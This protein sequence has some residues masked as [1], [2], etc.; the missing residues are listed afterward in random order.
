MLTAV[1]SLL[2]SVIGA[3]INSKAIMISATGAGLGQVAG[4]FVITWLEAMTL[5]ALAACISVV[6]RSTMG[7]VVACIVI[8]FV[9]SILSGAL[10]AMNPEPT[11][12]TLAIPTYS[13]DLLRH[14]VTSPSH[15]GVDGGPVGAAFL[16]LLGWTALLAAGAVFLFQRQDLTRE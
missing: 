2:A 10:G 7:A 11:W 16:V 15:L 12:K 1:L 14:F 3:E 6:A 9:Q 5:V 4:V 8:R 13:A